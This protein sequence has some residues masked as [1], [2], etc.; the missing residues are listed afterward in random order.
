MLTH[1]TQ[2]DHPTPRRPRRARG[3][4][5]GVPRHGELVQRGGDPVPAGIFAVWAAG[6]G[7]E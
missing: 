2:L 7:K 5:T 4:R 6:Y 1:L 3:R